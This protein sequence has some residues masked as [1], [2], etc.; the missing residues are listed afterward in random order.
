MK[1][2]KE[3]KKKT[4]EKA[5]HKKDEKELEPQYYRSVTGD[6]TLNYHVY[7]MSKLEKILYF[8]L[9]FCAGMAIGYLFYGGIGKDEYGEPTTVTY[10][11][12]TVIMVG[13][14]TLAGKLFLP[15]RNQQI[16]ENRKNKLKNQFRD[17][18]EALQTSLGSGKNIPDSFQSAYVDMMNQYEDGAFIINE[19]RVINNGIAN[20][21]NIEEMIADFGR[22]S[23]CMDIEDFAGVF[24]VCYRR[25]GNIRETIQNTCHIIIDK[26]M[27]AQ[28]IETTVTGSKNEQYIMLVLPVLLVGMIKSSSPD[29]AANFVTPTGLISTTIAIALFIASY[30]VGKKLLDIKV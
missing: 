11:L 6:Q 30:F 12:N 26:M 16:L 8:L 15:I 23:G 21:I 29:F 13:C 14:G 28:E 9:A 1:E 17:M 19:L 25:G 27:V 20:G 2:K 22:R 3:K 18:L 10:I 7:Y 5:V 4:K 24:E